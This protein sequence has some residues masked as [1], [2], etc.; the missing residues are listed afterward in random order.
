MSET[1]KIPGGGFST[2]I[3]VNIK[4]KEKAYYATTILLYYYT[5]LYYES[6]PMYAQHK[7][8]EDNPTASPETLSKDKYLQKYHELYNSIVF[9]FRSSSQELE[10]EFKPLSFHSLK[11]F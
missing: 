4:T 5:K 2:I 7:T 3:R 9:K 11:P 1:E 10:K 8:K 6:V